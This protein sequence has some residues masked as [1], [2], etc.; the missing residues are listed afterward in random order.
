MGTIYLAAR[1]SHILLL[2]HTP[3]IYCL[4]QEYMHTRGCIVSAGLERWWTRHWTVIFRELG[5]AILR[6]TDWLN[7]FQVEEEFSLLA[8]GLGLLS[9]LFQPS[10]SMNSPVCL[11]W[12]INAF[13]LMSQWCS[14]LL[15]LA[16]TPSQQAM[17]SFIPSLVSHH[18]QMLVSLTREMILIRTFVFPSLCWCRTLT[19]LLL[20]CCSFLTTTTLSSSTTTGSPALCAVR[21]LKTQLCASFVERS[22]VSRASA[23]NSRV[24]ASVCWWVLML[25]RFTSHLW[26]GCISRFYVFRV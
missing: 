5:I 26:S 9:A 7:V 11:E 3:F 6:L 10:T 25:C 2:T 22:S 21:H 16:D 15:R 19:G 18:M 1:Y 17:V 14:E 13:E 4:C 20:V 8:G 12:N 24:S 23:A